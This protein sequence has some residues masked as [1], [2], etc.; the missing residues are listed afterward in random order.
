MGWAEL[1]FTTATVGILLLGALGL[2]IIVA[3]DWNRYRERRR[4]ER[5]EQLR[6]LCTHSAVEDDRIRS[7]FVSPIGRLDW[8]CS[9]CGMTV[10][11]EETVQEMI[12]MWAR[13]PKAWLKQEKKFAK[14]ARKL[15]GV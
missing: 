8:V 3:F 1:L 7:L 4:K 6:V 2:K 14:M 13:N 12:R 15:Y 5:K 10:H 11:T 9:R